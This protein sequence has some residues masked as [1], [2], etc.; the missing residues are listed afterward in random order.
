MYDDELIDFASDRSQGT[1]LALNK[2]VYQYRAGLNEIQSQAQ[3]FKPDLK[4]DR[5]AFE[6]A[7]ETLRPLLRFT[8]SDL[9]RSLHVLANLVPPQ[10]P[11]SDKK[12]FHDLMPALTDDLL[13]LARQQDKTVS[14]SFSADRARLS[15]EIFHLLNAAVT[16]ICRELIKQTIETPSKRSE[17]GLSRS[18]HIALTAKQ[19]KHLLHVLI[20]C[21]GRK[22]NYGIMV[23]PAISKLKAI[24]MRSGFDRQGD[25]VSIALA[26]IP[27]EHRTD[28]ADVLTLL[29]IEEMS[30]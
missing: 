17:N 14:V 27:F 21:K 19:D 1:L 10:L 23:S 4:K 26:D 18:A 29:P 16:H 11:E 25:L 12:L 7:A 6:K 5:I 24:G 2:L 13:R 9:K 28:D 30:A 3:P 8:D 15:S 20:T 22:P